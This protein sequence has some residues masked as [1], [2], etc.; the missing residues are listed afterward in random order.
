MSCRIGS[1]QQRDGC[2][3]HHYNHRRETNNNITVDLI[4]TGGGLAQNPF[5]RQIYA[6]VTGRE[7]ALAGSEQ[8]S[9]L[10]AAMLGAVAAGAKAGGHDSLAE[11]RHMAPPPAKVYRPISEHIEPY[12]LLYTEYSRLCDYF[13][14]GE[15]RVMKV[16]RRL[17]QS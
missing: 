14:R 2:H 4:V 9:A 16:L 8:A 1:S 17:R 6:D 15:N 12:H 7:L 13:G 11:V 10:G 3:R 5:L